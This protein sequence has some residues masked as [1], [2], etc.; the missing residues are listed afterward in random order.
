[1]CVCLVSVCCAC[2]IFQSF[3]CFNQ[4]MCVVE[5]LAYV[6]FHVSVHGRVCRVSVAIC[7]RVWLCF[8]TSPRVCTRVC[9]VCVCVF[10]RFC[11]ALDI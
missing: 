4:R 8:R 10:V 2:C 1:M 3:V 9:E 7:S 6:F 11:L 5:L